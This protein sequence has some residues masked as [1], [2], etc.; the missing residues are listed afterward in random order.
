[1]R[2]RI[3]KRWM[4]NLIVRERGRGGR[5]GEGERERIKKKEKEKALIHNPV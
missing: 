1:M 5:R 2:E 3:R 4:S